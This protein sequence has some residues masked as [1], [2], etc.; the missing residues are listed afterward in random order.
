V[1]DINKEWE[2]VFLVGG[3]KTLRQ[4][5]LIGV[6]CLLIAAAA[7][8]LPTSA[9]GQFNSNQHP[10]TIST[11]ISKQNNKSITTDYSALAAVAADLSAPAEIFS[12]S[13]SSSA[14]KPKAL[15]VVPAAVFLV[16]AGFCCV[17]LVRDNKLWLAAAGTLLWAG[18]LTIHSLP[19]LAHLI[20]QKW[21]GPTFCTHNNN[22]H[23]SGQSNKNNRLLQNKA[24]YNTSYGKSPSLKPAGIIAA[25]STI[26]EINILTIETK[27]HFCFLPAF[28][29]KLIPRGPP[30]LSQTT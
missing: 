13:H 12:A 26:P 20:A 3:K 25:N 11:S 16:I 7:S 21:T 2:V 27:Q 10:S 15:P 8:A 1:K 17:S 30:N 23:I 28:I 5:A 6:L 18:Q 14:D 4:A 29:F 9:P 24:I 19:H 22:A